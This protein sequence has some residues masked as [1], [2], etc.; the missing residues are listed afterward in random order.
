MDLD[1]PRI[2]LIVLRTRDFERA[3]EFYE[4][5]LGLKQRLYDVAGGWCHFDAGAIELGIQEVKNGE[6]VGGAGSL[7]IAFQVAN[8]KR[9]ITNMK[10]RTVRFTSPIKYNKDEGFKQITAVDPDGNKLVFFQLASS[11]NGENA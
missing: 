10:N 1:K 6:E 7:Y 11:A 9:S 3:K 4:I 8:L 5:K 2:K